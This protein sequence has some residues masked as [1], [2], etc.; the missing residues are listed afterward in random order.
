MKADL[1]CPLLLPLAFASSFFGVGHRRGGD[2]VQVGLIKSGTVLVVAASLFA[3]P[4]PA[5]AAATAVEDSKDRPID[6]TCVANKE[7][8]VCGA[9]GPAEASTPKADGD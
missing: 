3:G 1:R 8:A 9:E 4:V 6:E 2:P 5:A 7:G